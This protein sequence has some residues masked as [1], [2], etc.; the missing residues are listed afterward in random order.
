MP[1]R[2]Y[3]SGGYGG[4]YDGGDTI[5]DLI[6]A[7]GQIEGR[8]AL[9]SGDIWGSALSRVG[10]ELGGIFR[11]HYAQKEAEK[12]RAAMAK[13]DEAWV[14]Y[15]EGGEWQKDP[16]AAYGVARRI[17]G[18]AEGPKQFAALEAI[19]RLGGTAEK[20]N[21]EEDRKNLGIVAS[22]VRKMDDPA[23]ARVWPSLRQLGAKVFPG[24]DIPEQFTPDLRASLIDPLAESLAGPPKLEKGSAGDVFFD[25]ATGEQKFAVPPKPGE[26]VQPRVVGRSLVTP[27][28]KV[29]YRDPETRG[30][31][32]ERVVQITGPQGTPIWVR[33]SEAVGKPAAQAARA[34]TGAERQS[35]A[36]FNRAQQASADIAPIEE[37][38]AKLGLAGQAG[39]QYLPNFLQSQEGQ[40]YRQ[41]QRAFTE[42]RLRKESGA[43][44]PKHEYENDARTYFA[45]P[46]DSPETLK[47]KQEAREVVLEGL[48][49]GAGRAYEEFYGEPAPKR[50]GRG[51][52]DGVSSAVQR[53]KDEV[54][55]NA[56]PPGAEYVDPTGKHRRKGR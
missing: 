45:Q 12:E 3:Y 42:A 51:A 5:R 8:G 43:A 35:L 31:K 4:G 18:P 19:Q 25:P 16:K 30:E 9:G 2:R 7:R 17:W 41:A 28:G 27:E 29:I 6:L 23:V 33:E 47:Q 24:A 22:A 37:N 11:Q 39:L 53:I 21:P 20:P 38:I 55:Y 14:S 49:F 50:K 36:Y 56:L 15:V 54:E 44:I 13:R 10:S 1:G 34:V 48:R 32:D 46:G 52:G 26:G 40:S